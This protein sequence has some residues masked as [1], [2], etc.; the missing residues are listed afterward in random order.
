MRELAQKLSRAR[1]VLLVCHQ[2]PDGDTMGSAL[3]LARGLRTLGKRAQVASEPPPD[4]YRAFPGAEE[5]LPPERIQPGFDL[6]ILVD[7]GEKQRAGCP[8]SLF[9]GVPLAIVDH[10]AN[11]VHESDCVVLDPRAGA[12][13]ELI[14]PLLDQL[15]CAVDPVSANWLYAALITDTGSFNF[16]NTTARTLEMGA[17]AVGA[18][19]DP[20]FV[21]RAVFRSKKLSQVRL[22]AASLNTLSIDG[23]F[24]WV[25]TDAAMYRETGASEAET[26]SIINHVLE[27][28]GVSVAAI[29][30][31][32]A[33][34]VRISFRSKYEV[35]VGR[36]AARFDGGGHRKA[37]GCTI[38]GSLDEAV[39]QVREQLMSR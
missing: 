2:N 30:K 35:D 24:A 4:V 29:F 16:S 17:R 9:A 23:D 13:A 25:H 38:P 6:A 5:L 32:R 22:L 10:H 15:G 28:E 26:D 20:E 34:D 36:I 14:F 3:A 21:S 19:A 1:Q 33:S 12:T 18:G 39:R 27:I 11:G 37:S 31:V 7:F 8:A